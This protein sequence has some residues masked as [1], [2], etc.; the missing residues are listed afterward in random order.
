[1][2]NLKNSIK[3]IGG[4]TALLGATT[5]TSLE[6][7]THIVSESLH[8]QQIECPRESESYFRLYRCI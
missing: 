2:I 8:K 3:T 5:F 4:A 1:M 6:A 7:G